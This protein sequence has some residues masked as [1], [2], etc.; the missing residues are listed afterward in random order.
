MNDRELI[1]L[2]AAILHEQRYGYSPEIAVEEALKIFLIAG[3]LTDK[4][5]SILQ[6]GHDRANKSESTQGDD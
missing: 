4:N 6:A 5:I 3:M 2:M 1:A